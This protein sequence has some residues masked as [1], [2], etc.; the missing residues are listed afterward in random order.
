ML[1]CQRILVK[2]KN[3]SRLF[4]RDLYPSQYMIS[5]YLLDLSTSIVVSFNVLAKLLITDFDIKNPS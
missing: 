3:K 2:K 5:K 1:S 4:K